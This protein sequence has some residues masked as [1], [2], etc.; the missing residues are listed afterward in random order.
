MNKVLLEVYPE[1]IQQENPNPKVQ[2][3]Y[4]TSNITLS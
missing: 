2:L 3:K 1:I 4:E